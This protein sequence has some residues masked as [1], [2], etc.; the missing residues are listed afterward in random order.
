MSVN[1]PQYK[2]RTV[3]QGALLASALGFFLKEAPTAAYAIGLPEGEIPTTLEGMEDYLARADAPMYILESKVPDT[4]SVTEGKIQISDKHGKVGPHSLQWD[5]ESQSELQIN[6]PLHVDVSNL[7]LQQ[8]YVSVAVPHFSFWI[9]NET[10]SEASLRVEFCTDK[11]INCWF[12]FNL[13]FTGW[14]TCWVR[15]GFDTQG[16][17]TTSMNRIVMRAPKQA[18]TIW[19]DQIITNNA[20]R[21]DQAMPDN[22]VPFVQPQVAQNQNYHW[23]GLRDYWTFMSDPGFDGSAPTAQEIADIEVI[24]QRLFEDNR[25]NK[26]FDTAAL[27]ALENKLAKSAVP[28]L[29]EQTPGKPPILASSG[30]FANGYQTDL[31]P[32][33]IKDSLMKLVGAVPVK[34]VMDLA[35][36][37]ARTW[38]S[39]NRAGD[40]AAAARAATSYLRVMAYLFDQGWSYG[41]AQGTVHH[42]GY[43]WRS[44]AVSIFIAQE[45]LKQYGLW[46]LARNT[47]VWYAGLG[48][49]TLSFDSEV[50]YSG[51]IDVLNTLLMGLLIACVIPDEQ[52]DQVGRL[53]AFRNWL[54]NA[55]EP[56]PGLSGGFKPDGTMYHHKGLYMAYGRDALSGAIPVIAIVNGT[57][58]SLDPNRRDILREALIVQARISNTLEY[59]IA[60]SGRHPHGKDG[61]RNAHVELL[62]LLALRPLDPKVE[63]DTELAGMFRHLLPPDASTRMKKMDQQFANLGIEPLVP[64][65]YWQYGYGAA[66]QSRQDQWNVTVRGHNRY[67]WTAE[68]YE[69]KNLYGRYLTYGN[70]EIQ[71]LEDEKSVVTHA[72]NGWVHPGWDWRRMPGA[73]TIQI[74]IEKMAINMDGLIEVMPMPRPAFGGGGVMHEHAALFGMDLEEHPM[75]NPTHKARISALL[76]E[77]RVY[78]LG[79][80]ISNNDAKNPTYTTLFQMA[81]EVMT[82][83]ASVQTGDTWIVDPGG[84]GFAVLEGKLKSETLKQTMPDETGKETGTATFSHGWIDHGK[85]PSE[86]GYAYAILV[87]QGVQKTKEFAAAPT[88]KIEQRDRNAHVFTDTKTTVTAYVVFEPD[89]ELTATSLLQ[90]ATRPVLA[91]SR[92]VEDKITAWSITDPDLHLFEGEDKEQ[93]DAEGHYVGNLLPYSR[94]WRN[95]PSPVTST[96]V[97]LRGQ[98]ELVS[99]AA[100]ANASGKENT[101]ADGS[102]PEVAVK[103]DGDNTVVTTTTAHA[104]S[105]EFKLR[106]I[107]AAQPTPD[108]STPAPTGVSPTS[109][110]S[111]RPS[112]P[113]S[114]LP[115]TGAAIGAAV[116]GAGVAGAGGIAALRARHRMLKAEETAPTQ[117]PNADQ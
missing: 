55:C 41:S 75:F 45:L 65:G 99:P 19:I 115:T 66:A 36:E 28:K 8:A 40:T 95:N 23:L 69:A 11:E 90:S 111:E 14:R 91:L 88:L 32:K 110:G 13:D 3:L 79:S 27:D 22:Q 39:A 48:R 81:P 20:W 7:D 37:A 61:L 97:T 82:K 5:F 94:P 12:D 84:N 35:L 73:T 77:D 72:A 10:P 103:I 107:G 63:V 92:P 46:E 74:P 50:A 33:E 29:A 101:T 70:I 49:L 44:W 47:V 113:G 18:G 105:I 83:P 4:F 59:P 108:P 76:V 6:T 85:A 15:Y 78:A 116:L 34:Q 67:T 100:E 58:F 53:R 38:D 31:W 26:K 117:G 104:R 52:I 62:G 60:F 1:I 21:G 51:L 68:T 56:S 64:H 112:Q 24:K 114:S 17:P 86:S 93:Y 102:A 25:P 106:Q 16:M 98:W 109:G 57:A 43:Q 9:Y 2:R 42:L 96:S 54:N 89:K 30:P 80:N 71:A 87:Q